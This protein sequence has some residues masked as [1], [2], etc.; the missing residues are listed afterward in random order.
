MDVRDGVSRAPAAR[1]RDCI[2]YRRGTDG[3]GGINRRSN[4]TIEAA[5]SA[6][7]I[8]R[9]VGGACVAGG[10]DYKNGFRQDAFHAGG[11]GKDEDGEDRKSRAT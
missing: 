10:A 9:G 8:A 4:P 3:E 2:A 11:L 6:P 7:T 5:G 1:R